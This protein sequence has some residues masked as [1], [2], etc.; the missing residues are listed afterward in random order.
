MTTSS[1]DTLWYTRC[2]TL[3]AS[4]IAIRDGW[5]ERAFEPLGILVRS[6]TEARDRDTHESH[7]SHSK[8][9]SFRH[10]GN[11]PPLWAR[12]EGQPTRLLGL[13]W[14]ET[15]YAILALPESGIHTVADLAGK[16]L[17][18]PRRTKDAVDFARAMYLQTYDAALASAGMSRDEVSIVD[19][20]VTAGFLDDSAGQVKRGA[21]WNAVQLRGFQ[22]TEICALLNGQVDA[23]A[24][25]GYW[26]AE[27]IAMFGAIS[28]F[29]SRSL[30][31]RTERANSGNP[32]LLTV[33]SALVDERPDLIVRWLACLMAAG[34]WGRRHVGDSVRIAAQETGVAEAFVELNGEEALLG[35][36]DI[37]FDDET[38]EALRAQKARLLQ[39]GFIGRDIDLDAW[40]APE[41]LARARDEALDFA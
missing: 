38:V 12:S 39:N 7:F 32:S 3:T 5:L 36:L 14:G 25:S 40:M 22:R 27:N 29:D 6:L 31:S 34:D 24:S 37:G 15:P 16:R 23:I 35:C 17:A 9:N 1:L 8:P 18:L 26:I 4:S 41:L 30:P 21:L 28:V 10:G 20:P 2:P 19:L 13:T 11:I 33:S